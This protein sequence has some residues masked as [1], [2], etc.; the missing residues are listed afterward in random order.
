MLISQPDKIFISSAN[1]DMR[2][3]IDGLSSIVEQ[4][5]Q[6]SQFDDAMFGFHNRHCDKIK[7]LYWDS[8]GFCLLYKRI[9]HGKFCF[10]QGISGDKYSI[11]KDELLWL[12]HG[13][14]IE[15]I[16]KYN[17]LESVR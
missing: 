17:S 6:L 3:S 1:V 11:T 16:H 14:K 15:E 12:L 13:L 9:E 5:F 4:C 8:D 10:P 7:I 2:K